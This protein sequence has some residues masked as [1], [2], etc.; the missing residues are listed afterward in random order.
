M[1]KP[2]KD[3]LPAL[4]A[5][6]GELI[7]YI[8]HICYEIRGFGLGRQA[9]RLMAALKAMEPPTLEGALADLRVDKAWVTRELALWMAERIMEAAEIMNELMEDAEITGSDRALDRARAWL[10]QMGLI[11]TD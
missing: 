3:E 4:G 1:S 8:E 9:D 5:T 2:T 10:D 6:Q 11:R 7:A